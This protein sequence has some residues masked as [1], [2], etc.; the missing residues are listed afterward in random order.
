MTA[1]ILDYSLEALVQL[2]AD[3]G[4]PRY[5]AVQVVQWVHQR[6]VT[7]FAQMTNLSLSLREKLAAAFCIALPE[8]AYE[9][10]S[11]DGTIKWLLRLHDGNCI[12]TV[13][14]PETTRGTLCVSSQV[15]CALNCTFCSTG[16]EGFNRNLSLGEIIGQLWL[17]RQQLLALSV[18]QKVTNVVMMGM[19]EPLLNYDQVLPALKLMLD[20]NAYGLSKYRVTVSTSGVV[21]AMKRLQQ[22]IPVALAVSLHAPN[23]ALRAQLVPLNKKYPLEVLMPVCKQYFAGAA[24]REVTYEYV[25]LAGVN[26]SLQ[27]ADELVALLKGSQAKVNLIPFNPFD[28]AQYKTSPWPVIEAFQRRLMAGGIMTWV[29]KTRGDDVDAACGQ[30][31]GKITDRTGRHKRWLATGKVVPAGS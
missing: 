5:R 25:M 27:Q 14:I 12:E 23:N 4:E 2:F 1:N 13:F 24:K 11:Q 9:K 3:W 20:D 19:G 16:K 30:L 7:D 10:Q 6:A 29:R 21:P 26:D 17:A 18:T 8:I 22:D 31:A 15:G 28:R